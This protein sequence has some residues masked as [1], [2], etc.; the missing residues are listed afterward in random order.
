MFEVVDDEQHPQAAQGGVQAALRLSARD[1]DEIETAGEFGGHQC[2]VVQIGEAHERCPVGERWRQ[3]S[4]DLERHLGLADT[5]GTD[6]R[7]KSEPCQQVD[8]T[9]DV[10]LAP[11]EDG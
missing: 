8:H 7:H 5:T 2:G 6:H 11:D 1:V 9:S 10:T 4:G 3:P